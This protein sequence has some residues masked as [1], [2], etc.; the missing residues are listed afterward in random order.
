MVVRA[1]SARSTFPGA[2]IAAEG[3]I[4]QGPPCIGIL[5]ARARDGG[6]AM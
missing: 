5:S 2:V 4:P 6:G 3:G 1:V